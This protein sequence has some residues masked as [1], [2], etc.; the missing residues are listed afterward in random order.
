MET[1]FDAGRD[2]L[3]A[4]GRF[5]SDTVENTRSLIG[6]LTD[7]ITHHLRRSDESDADG[8]IAPDREN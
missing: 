1:V 5:G 6:G 7:R 8:P 3:Q 2:G 4:A